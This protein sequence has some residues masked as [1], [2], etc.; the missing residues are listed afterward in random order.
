[1]LTYLGGL[2]IT[3]IR[4]VLIGDNGMGSVLKLVA[5]NSAADPLVIPAALGT[6]VRLRKRPSTFMA[7]VHLLTVLG[8]DPLNKP[9]KKKSVN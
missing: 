7:M 8:F 6:W 3:I 4:V 2:V 1:M 5:F 9:T